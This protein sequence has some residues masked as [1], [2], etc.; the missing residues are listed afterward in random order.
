MPSHPA[1]L[2]VSTYPP[3][4]CGLANFSK[5]LLDATAGVRGSYA[6]LGVAAVGDPDLEYASEVVSYFQ[7][8][9]GMRMPRRLASAFDVAL[10]QHEFGIFGEDDGIGVLDL[11]ASS[12]IPVITVL[13]TV[14]AEPSKRQ[15]YIIET[16]AEQSAGLVVMSKAARRRLHD[17]YDVDGCPV[18]MIP[19]GA[20]VSQP[21][22][23]A[24]KLRPMILSWGLLGPG[25]GLESGI[26][27]MRRL[28]HLHPAPTYVIAGQTHPNVLKSQGETY[29]LGLMQLAK[30]LGVSDMVR[31]VNRYLTADDLTQ[32][33][34]EASVALLPYENRVQVT[35]GA[36]VEALG[37]GVPVVATRFPH[38]VEL[39]DGGAGDLVE[40]GDSNAMAHSLERLLVDP[41]RR[42]TA[43]SAIERLKPQLS[44]EGVGA[45]YH[46]LF[47]AAADEVGAA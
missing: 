14:L 13:H 18:E 8:E 17:H 40:L 9:A 46:R 19:H 43:T 7:P 16:L 6:G 39:L 37:A 34:S 38:A 1:V 45:A 31:F 23:F 25:K 2:L 33:R 20:V 24:K 10:I 28:R 22:V 32:L 15:R 42:A 47:A 4:R 3:T 30:D 21:A 26:R 41:A 11:V 29:R 35:S 36:L 12:T 44:W 27:A 5:S